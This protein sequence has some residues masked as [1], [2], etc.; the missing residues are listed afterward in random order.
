MDVN[1][2]FLQGPLD[3][4]VF[5][6]QPSRFVDPNLPTYV[7][8]LNKAIHGLK[9]APRV[10]YNELRCFLLAIDFINSMTDA[11]LFIYRHGETTMYLLVC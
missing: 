9:Q 4:D 5:M 10:W 6:S 3:E 2:A 7:C 1:N 11:S 8:K